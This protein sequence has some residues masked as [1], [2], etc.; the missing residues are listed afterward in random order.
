MA[1]KVEITDEMVA[2]GAAILVA[3]YYLDGL[4]EGYAER[5]T[6]RVLAAALEI[7]VAEN[8]EAAA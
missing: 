8:S 4:G 7:P 6:R 2:R 1:P 5:L 3:D